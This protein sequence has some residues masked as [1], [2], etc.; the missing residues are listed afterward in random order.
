M[1]YTHG[2]YEGSLEN[3]ALGC[4]G[5]RR[6]RHARGVVGQQTGGCCGDAERLWGSPAAGDAGDG[7]VGRSMRCCQ[8]RGLFPPRTDTCGALLPSQH[9]PVSQTQPGQV[10]RANKRQLFG[11]FNQERAPVLAMGLGNGQPRFTPLCRRSQPTLGEDGWWGRGCWGDPAL[12]NLDGRG[13]RLTPRTPLT[14]SGRSV[15]AQ[16]E[17]VT[18]TG[19]PVPLRQALEDSVASGRAHHPPLPCRL[20]ASPARLEPCPVPRPSVVCG[21][22]D[23]Q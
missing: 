20:R 18:R 6:S 8:A 16:R 11:A 21:T 2:I 23:G 15:W 19:T 22:T 17:T 3:I 7:A 5:R 4:G 14:I 13:A 10:G 1:N 9:C 12:P